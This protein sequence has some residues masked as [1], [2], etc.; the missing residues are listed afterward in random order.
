VLD[1]HNARM[2]TE[3]T[4][5]S[6]LKLQKQGLMDDLLTGRVRVNSLEKLGAQVPATATIAKFWD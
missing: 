5:L 4:Y 1:S 6:K 3:E 2:Y